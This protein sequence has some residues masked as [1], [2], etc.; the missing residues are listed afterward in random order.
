[1]TEYINANPG[2]TFVLL[3]ILI[4]GVTDALEAFANHRR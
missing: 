1:M 2:Y 3:L 4:W